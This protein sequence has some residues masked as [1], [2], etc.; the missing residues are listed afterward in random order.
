MYQPCNRIC[1]I[2]SMQSTDNLV[3]EAIELVLGR[4]KEG[5]THAA[6]YDRADRTLLRPK[7]V[8]LVAVVSHAF[9][10]T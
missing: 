2:A 8:P 9:K 10:P 5:I 4:F 3:N 6:L 1:G 7:L